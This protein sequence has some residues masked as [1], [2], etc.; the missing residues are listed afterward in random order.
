MVSPDRAINQAAG[1]QRE[2]LEPSWETQHHASAQQDSVV[3]RP[4]AVLGVLGI[5]GGG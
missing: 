5:S 3:Q 2:S 1:V 4:L